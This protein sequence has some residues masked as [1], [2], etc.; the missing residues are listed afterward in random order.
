M[1]A[2]I[3]DEITGNWKASVTAVS[4]GYGHYPDE[5]LWSWVE[6]VYSQLVSMGEG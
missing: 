6:E 3:S 1:P 2:G 4:D 5:V